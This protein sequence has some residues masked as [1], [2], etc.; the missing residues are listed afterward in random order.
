MRLTDHIPTFMIEEHV[1]AALKEDLGLGG[2]RTTNSIIPADLKAT[3][4]IIARQEGTCAGLDL[5]QTAYHLVDEKLRFTSPLE[6]G[7][8]FAAG[9]LIAEIE[10]PARALL[11][12][13][14]VALNFLG[15]LCGIASHTRLFVDETSHTK[16]HI[17]CTRKTTPGLRGLEKY[18]VKCG[19]GQNHRFRLDDGILIKDNH[20]AIAGGVKN[21]IEQAQNSA[22]HMIKIQ[23]EVDNLDQLKTVLD[24]KVDA[25]LLDNMPPEVLKQAVEMIDGKLVS[26]ASGGVNLDSVKAIAETGVDLISVGALTHSSPTLDLGLDFATSNS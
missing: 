19:G 9:A 26:E 20:I 11:T 25:V 17:C 5:A 14:R 24:H 22:G 1:S 13:E 4:K 6:D 23:V 10:G 18:A 8:H 2:D 15:H 3:G 21:A 12:A 7:A 16:A